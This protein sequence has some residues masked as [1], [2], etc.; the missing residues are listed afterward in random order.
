MVSS[1]LSLNLIEGF[2]YLQ[3]K[4]DALHRLDARRQTPLKEF[5]NLDVHKYLHPHESDDR[6]S[7]VHTWST[8]KRE[9]LDLTSAFIL[10]DSMYSFMPSTREYVGGRGCQCASL[11]PSGV[12]IHVYVCVGVV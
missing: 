7:I 6:V 12:F 1:S 4:S 9:T 2:S 10:Y 8:R 11:L 5:G 3:F